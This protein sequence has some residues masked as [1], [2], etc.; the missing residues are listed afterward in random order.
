MSTGNSARNLRDFTR[1]WDVIYR[2]DPHAVRPFRKEVTE[3]LGGSDPFVRRGDREVFVVTADDGSPLARAV[4]WYTPASDQH[5]GAPTGLF[6]HFESVNSDQPVDLLLDAV[7]RWLADRGAVHITGPMSPKS[8]EPVGV[9]V[10]GP[11]R[12][13][14][15]MPYNPPYYPDLLA[16]A[17]LTAAQDLLQ[18]TVRLSGDYPRLRSVAALARRRFPQLRVRGIDLANFEADVRHL[19]TFHNCT[20]RDTWG[21]MPMDFDEVWAVAKQ[22]RPFYRPEYGLIAEVDGE[23]VG[24]AIAVPDANQVLHRMAGRL[25]PFGWWH[26]LTGMRGIRELR[27]L[28][29]GVEPRFRLTGMDA[30]VMSEWLDR[31]VSRHGITH[32]HLGWTPESNTRLHRQ[33][34]QEAGPENVTTKRFRVYRGEA[35]GGR[36]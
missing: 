4:A 30:L 7:R 3:A 15:G 28:Y 1:L 12:P 18:Q 10:D 34:E 31:A 8:S 13:V 24:M 5:R 35:G 14:Y 17:G 19:V 33:V 23:I 26:L 36:R 25:W 16:G 6:S 21:F 29:I 11:G 20:N 22:F 32:V 9:L 2:G 27:G